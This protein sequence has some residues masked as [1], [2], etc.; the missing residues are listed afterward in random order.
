M[1][2]SEIIAVCSHIHTKHINTLCTQNMEFVNVK[3]GGT[4]SYH[5]VLGSS[6]RLLLKTL[7]MHKWAH[8]ISLLTFDIQHLNLKPKPWF[9]Y[10]IRLLFS[11]FPFH[12]QAMQITVPQYS[13]ANNI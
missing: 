4:Y 1:L 3:P 10:K 6:V 5:W 12:N 11:L 8:L 13:V 9:I 2:Y 7:H